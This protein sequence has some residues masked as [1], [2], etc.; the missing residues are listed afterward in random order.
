M[1]AAS[2]T[3]GHPVGGHHV[4]LATPEDAEAA[5]A[6]IA[7]LCLEDGLGRTALTPERFR[8]DGFGPLPLFR[9]LLAERDGRP[10]GIVLL[11]HGYDSVSATPG[12]VLEDLYVEP[13][14]RRHGVGTALMAAAAR[15]ARDE[16]G[17]WLAWHMRRTNV[18]GQLF[19]R[20]L[21]A[22]QEDV[23][24]MSL[25]DEAFTALVNRG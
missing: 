15:L 12:L 19:Y 7:S 18:R 5:A 13:L 20:A 9:A 21:G 23:V 8:A 24:L 22:D 3:G 11:T 2:T 14:A 4:R 17:H 25:A 6:L 1:G 10:A 16:G